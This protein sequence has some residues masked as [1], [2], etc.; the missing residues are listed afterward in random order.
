MPAILAVINHW[1]SAE[2][3]LE[4]AAILARATGAQLQVYC[5]VSSEV[6]ELNRYI[7]FDNYE[8]VKEELLRENRAR[9]EELLEG[10]DSDFLVEWQPRSYRGV[11][12]HA[13][14]VS[15]A[16]IIMSASEHSI[17]G[18]F[19]HKPDDWHLLRDAPCPVMIL[20]HE[21]RPFRAVVAAVDALDDS[22]G[23]EPLNARILDEARM[24]SEAFALPLSVVSVVPD[25][26]YLYSDLSATDTSVMTRF[27]DQARQAA[28][29]RQQKLLEHYGVAVHERQVVCG[30]VEKVLHEAVGDAGLLVIGTIANKGLRGF[31]L[32]NTAERLLQR[33][34]GD[35]LV[36]N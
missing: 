23:A 12:A 31:F 4:R 6:E 16:L 15:A 25:P 32:G 24:L 11:S 19:L 2:R 20:S 13:E 34:K 17:V 36:V 5:P 10:R 33:Q 3:I 21:P 29:R 27:R 22:E 35:M 26:V 14:A 30:R 7:G 28:D 9:L 18:D 8:E 1:P